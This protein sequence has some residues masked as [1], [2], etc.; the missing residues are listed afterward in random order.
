MLLFACSS[1]SSE[2]DAPTST[3]TDLEEEINVSTDDTSDICFSCLSREQATEAYS[4]PATSGSGSDLLELNQIPDAILKNMTTKGL[5]QSLLTFP[6]ILNWTLNN[7]SAYGGFLLETESITIFPEL[8]KRSDA[9]TCLLDL[10]KVYDQYACD[11]GVLTMQTFDMILSLPE[12][13]TK[14]TDKEITELFEAAIDKIENLHK[15]ERDGDDVLW[16]F[17][18]YKYLF[19]GRIMYYVGYDP[20]VASVDA[21][22][23]LVNFLEK[24]ENFFFYDT[25]LCTPERFHEFFLTQAKAFLNQRK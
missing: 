8:F 4:F 12:I 5:V 17:D 2:K 9:A 16:W 20:L 1:E 11:G 3:R 21:D 10:Y 7:Y 23:N 14:F 13:Y 15:D 24:P 18:P 6:T 19:M 25:G 22:E